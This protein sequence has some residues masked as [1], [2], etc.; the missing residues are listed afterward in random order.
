M[1]S[2]LTSYHTDVG[3]KKGK[4]QDSILL[5]GIA[6]HENEIVLLALCDGMGGMSKGELASATVINELSNWFQ[7]VYMRCG[8]E[9]KDEEIL[10]QW[11]KL[12]NHVNNK[13]IL[14]GKKEREQLGTTATMV[15]LSSTG[16]YLIGHVGDTRAYRIGERI[17]QLTEDHSF[18][19]REVRRGNMTLQQAAQDSRRNVLLQCIGINQYLEPQFLRGELKPGEA[20]LVCSDGFRHEVTEKEIWSHL[21]PR[22]H[23]SES[24]IKKTL[25]VLTELNKQ[26]M[27]TDNISAIYI[28]KK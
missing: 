28:K 9:W 15:L 11:K 24:D 1:N 26:R 12:L 3:I 8:S 19:A 13:L 4:N 22:I 5:K 18:V 21:N 6:I 17:E 23:N 20:I 27:E 2:F 10:E 14:Y 7:D 16:K 25:V